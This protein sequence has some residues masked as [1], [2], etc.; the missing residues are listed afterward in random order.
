MEFREIPWKCKNSAEKG[1]FRGLAQNSACRGKLWSLVITHTNRLLYNHCTLISCSNARP[2]SFR[3]FSNVWRIF[4]LVISF[5]SSGGHLR[6][7]TS[8]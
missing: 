6:H 7:H 1:K 5:A 3:F 2:S 4:I 8:T